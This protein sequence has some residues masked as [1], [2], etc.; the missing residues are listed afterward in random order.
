MW[1]LH[2][3]LLALGL[4]LADAKRLVNMFVLNR[5]V[6]AKA[7]TPLFHSV[8]TRRAVSMLLVLF[9]GFR[10]VGAAR[11]AYAGARLW[12]QMSHPLTGIY[13]VVSF[14]R[15]DTTLAALLGDSTRWRQLVIERWG[16][17]C[18]RKMN[19]DS[20]YYVADADTAHHRLV[21]R[22]NPRGATGNVF[23]SP[24]QG[25]SDVGALTFD[26][27]ISPGG[28]M[29]L[30]GTSGK[31]ALQIQLMRFDEQKFRLRSSPFRWII[32]TAINR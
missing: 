15:N 27:E 12:E 26:Y 30:R 22:L 18:V 23:R 6:P 4:V 24:P 32:D 10:F 8:G 28:S 3:W 2:L 16:G 11:D 7:F 19:D 14:V 1:A 25:L 5:P 21:L 9:A 17:V 20:E 31:D 13:D 29:M